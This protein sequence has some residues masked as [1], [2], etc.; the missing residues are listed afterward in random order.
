MA[1]V[2]AGPALVA[3]TQ[4]AGH[5]AP[6]RPRHSA[7]TWPTPRSVPGPP[8][9]AGTHFRSVGVPF[10]REP[11]RAWGPPRP[12][13]REPRG[14]RDP[15]AQRG[16]RPSGLGPSWAVSPAGCPGVGCRPHCPPY[17]SLL[18]QGQVF[19]GCRTEVRFQRKLWDLK[20]T[21]GTGGLT[22]T[23][24]ESRVGPEPWIPQIA[25]VSPWRV[26]RPHGGCEG[27]RRR[28]GGELPLPPRRR[29]RVPGG[30][31]GGAV[32]HTSRRRFGK[33]ARAGR[34]LSVAVTDTRS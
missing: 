24:R 8:D 28:A 32:T 5:R 19:P 2:A 34:T 26:L 3:V 6:A 18:E 27:A 16:W 30:L 29:P 14:A 21:A 22:H 9:G 1:P 4:M 33:A 11:R 7:A 10:G 12:A 15:R 31:V 23:R 25:R 17:G 13:G 20:E